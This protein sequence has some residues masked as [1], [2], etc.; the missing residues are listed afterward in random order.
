MSKTFTKVG[1]LWFSRCGSCNSSKLA[2]RGRF[3]RARWIGR[4]S[5]GSS[6][7]WLRSQRSNPGERLFR[8]YRDRLTEGRSTTV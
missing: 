6:Y 4:S 2:T 8:T 3:R 7:S 5:H 1:S